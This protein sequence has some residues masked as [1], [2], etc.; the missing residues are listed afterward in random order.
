V[1]RN[2]NAA[3]A[4]LVGLVAVGVL[5][6]AAAAVRLLEEIGLLEAVGAVPLA[7]LLGLFALVL[8]RRA[9][10]EH[11]RS[12]GRVGGRGLAALATVFGGA[13]LLLAVTAALALAVFAVLTLAFD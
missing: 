3:W 10:V 9:R 8:A 13:A 4:L 5:G 2:P 12:L 7:G 1:V 11:Q 6:A